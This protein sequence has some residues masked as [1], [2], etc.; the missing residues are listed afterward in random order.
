MTT[1]DTQI[2]LVS[3]TPKAEETMGYVARVSNP[4]N[5]DNPKVSG[6]LSY[7]INMGI[8]VSLSKHT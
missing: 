8:G 7:C 3:V 6:L 1:M 5:Q 2:K 4:Q